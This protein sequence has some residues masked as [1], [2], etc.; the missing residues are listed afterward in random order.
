M[1]RTLVLP[2]LSLVCL[3][4]ATPF[5]T[6]QEAGDVLLAKENLGGIKIGQTEKGLTAILGQPKSKS[7]ALLEEATG[8]YIQ[9]WSYPDKGLTVRLSS[10]SA[11]SARSVAGFTATE[12]CRLATTAGIKIGSTKA[13]VVKAYGAFEDKE[14]KGTAEEDGF[15]A[16]S[17]Y[18]GIIFTFKNGR[19]SEIFFGAAAE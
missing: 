8:E 6:A 16:G 3:L 4:I 10:E 17:I 9:N 2:V 14:S 11:K 15:I 19:V 1:H 12:K 7:K 5:T 13:E 18:G